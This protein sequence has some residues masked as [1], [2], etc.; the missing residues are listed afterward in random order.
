VKQPTVLVTG[1]GAPGGVTILK[2]LRYSTLRPRIVAV[3]LDPYA[4]GLYFADAA[5]LLP[6]VAD[7]TYVNRLAELC[8]RESVDIAFIGSEPEIRFLLE[9]VDDLQQRTGTVFMISRPSLMRDCMDKLRTAR[10]LAGLGFDTPASADGSD[11][12]AVAELVERF[13]FPVFIKP[14]FG[15]GSKMASKIETAE[16]LAF[17]LKHVPEPVVQEVLPDTD[18]EFTV[19][20]YA[21][22]DGSVA[23]SVASRR[24]LA[25]GLT[26]RAYF[27]SYPEVEAYCE[28][29]AAAIRP[30]GPCNFQLS[31]S[32]ERMSIFEINPRCSSST[33]M[34]A[35]LG[36]NEPEM[37]VREHVLDETIERPRARDGV[38]LRFWEEAFVDVDPDA[39]LPSEWGRIDLPP[40]RVHPEMMGN[41]GPAGTPS[42]ARER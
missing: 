38:V 10:L 27:G 29:A 14:R 18:G 21:R 36:F 25:A 42:S 20:V 33:V 1:V 2:A 13:G 22:K 31:K 37:A 35:V 11:P 40:A 30:L 17:Y 5:Y 28:R 24:D 19:G 7:P 8:E 39:G 34:R 4:V 16:E 41:E 12:A 23:G 26:Y 9:H 6:R 32:G 3:D 15:S